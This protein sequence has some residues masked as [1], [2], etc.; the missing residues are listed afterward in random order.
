M[1][2]G[3]LAAGFGDRRGAAGLDGSDDF[4]AGEGACH[5]FVESVAAEVP[6]QG[7]RLCLFLY[8]L[9]DRRRVEVDPQ[10]SFSRIASN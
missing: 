7:L 9:H 1:H 10:R 8:K 3:E 5:P 2:A 4:D 6:P